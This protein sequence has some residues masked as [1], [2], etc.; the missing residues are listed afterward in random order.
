MER[1]NQ[2][3]RDVSCGFTL[4]HMDS[5]SSRFTGSSHLT[6]KFTQL[7]LFFFLSSLLSPS[8]PRLSFP[9][10]DNAPA[11]LASILANQSVNSSSPGAEAVEATEASRLIGGR[12]V[13]K[14]PA[15]AEDDGRRRGRRVYE[16]EA[17]EEKESR[18]ESERF[19]PEGKERVSARLE[20]GVGSGSWKRTV[21]LGFDLAGVDC[22]GGLLREVWSEERMD[23]WSVEV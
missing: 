19:G 18:E 20:T 23:D 8:P 13:L 21:R 10:P 2:K 11:R 12:T 5:H 3:K 7:L 6:N 17:S 14:G 16:E 9:D 22:V 15:N 4:R 1:I